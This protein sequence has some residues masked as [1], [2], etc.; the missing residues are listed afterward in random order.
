M[1]RRIPTA[2]LAIPFIVL[3][4][5][6]NQAHS[7][8]STSDLTQNL[9][10][11]TRAQVKTSI[12]IVKRLEQT[13]YNHIYLDDALS[14]QIYDRY[15]KDL[16][17]SHSYFLQSDI[18][19]FEVYRYELDNA[20]KSGNLAPAYHV[21]N[22]Y[23]I[24]LIDRLTYVLQSLESMTKFDFSSAE[25][26]E[27]D[28]EDAPWLT[29]QAQLNSLWDKRLKHMVLNQKLSGNDNDK[30]KETLI[31]RFKNQLNRVQQTASQDA[32]QIY[33]NALT[34]TY[35]PHT[36]YFSP[37]VSENFNINMSL[38]L[39]GIGAVLQAEDEYTKIVRLVTGGPADK[40]NQLKPAD[41][42]IGVAQGKGEMSDV[43]GWRLDDVVSRIR[44]KKG[45]V[46]RLKVIPANAEDES[47]TK[48]V[49]ITRDT[50]KLE[51]RA[52]QSTV[53]EIKHDGKA[54]KLGIIDIPTFYADFQAMQN[55]DPNYK[56]TTRDVT[57]LIK[58]L[59]KQNVDGIIIDLRNNGGGSL[60]E[61]NSL[62]GLFIDAGPTVQVKHSSGHIEPWE[63][64]D[65]RIIYG[66]P[67]AVVINRLSAS[68]SEIFAGA[69]QDYGR[70]LI[71]G[72][73]SFGK[74]TVQ[75]LQSLRPIENGQL[76][77]T[78]AK[79]YRISGESNQHKGITPDILFPSTFN[80]DE[81]GESALANALPSDNIRPARFK[82]WS[83]Y[84]QYLNFLTAA[85]NERIATNPDFVFT[86]EQ[87]SSL[88]EIRRKTVVSLNETTR[89]KEQDKAKARG[90]AMENKKRVAKGKKPYKDFKA[91]TTA[92]EEVED[93][94][95]H[96]KK[97]SIDYILTEAGYILEDLISVSPKTHVAA[98]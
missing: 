49:S 34:Q 7:I 33:I 22:R 73:R 70:G 69:I 45:S 42:I 30:I 79:F 43:V 54:K 91:F 36:Q 94:N 61:A 81:I 21:F 90:L 50:V 46:V 41:R 88:N 75:S 38:Q 47:I 14:S 2:L 12:S 67:M 8:S 96:S 53:L 39:Q 93:E 98:H 77:V 24:R 68:A 18:K 5:I 71:I 56:S 15:I 29:S 20:L 85:H 4:L 48:I 40:S 76:K 62:V 83:S 74:G 19:E 52:A 9:L 32:F 23:Q 31:K 66:G 59:E 55:G 92:V 84:D 1:I 28:R 64:T 89:I 72:G 10:S 25:T 58:E 86:N 57:R 6:A 37:R 16:D 95:Q 87:I 82:R 27:T 26:Y 17:S 35:D 78:S 65:E 97:I 51:D 60:N 3:S 13:H 11:P 80:L 63:D 44:G